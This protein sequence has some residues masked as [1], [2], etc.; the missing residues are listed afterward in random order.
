VEEK[1]AKSILLNN[2]PS[3]YNI[4]IF[5]LSKMSSQTLED[6]VFP[7]LIKENRENICVIEGDP[8]P[9]IAL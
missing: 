8:Q 1:D 7:L 4:F 5:T 6:M 9:E 2:L 3:N